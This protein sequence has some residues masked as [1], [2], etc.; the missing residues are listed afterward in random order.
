MHAH[1]LP[2]LPEHGALEMMAGGKTVIMALAGQSCWYTEPVLQ[3]PE[4]KPK[5]GKTIFVKTAVM[6]MRQQLKEGA[7]HHC[8]FHSVDDEALMHAK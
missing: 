3:K 6:S 7:L 4:F 1:T 5:W 8:H 2:F